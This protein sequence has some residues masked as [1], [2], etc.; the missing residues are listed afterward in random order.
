MITGRLP[1]QYDRCRLTLNLPIFFEEAP[2]T[3]IRKAF[4]L[5]GDRLYQNE[6]TLELL[7]RFFSMWE[8]DVKDRL[9]LRKAGLTAAKLSTSEL[10]S[11]VACFGSVAT[12]KMIADLK[13]KEKDLN[14]ADREV[15]RAQAVLERCGKVIN[16]YNQKLRK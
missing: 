8:Q 9:E 3:N 15:K 6:N 13:A 16:A 14:S 11:Q 2:L 4:K 7:E 10:R 1:I 5:I 12:K